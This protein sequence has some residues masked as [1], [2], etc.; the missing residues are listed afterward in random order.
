MYFSWLFRIQPKCQI[1]LNSSSI[2]CSGNVNLDGL[3]A[4]LLRRYF[5]F[6]TQLLRLARFHDLN[7][8]PFTQPILSFMEVWLTLN[9]NCTLVLWKLTQP[10]CLH[11]VMYLVI[12][13]CLS[14]RRTAE[15]RLVSMFT[16]NLQKSVSPLRHWSEDHFAKMP[17]EVFL[18][19]PVKKWCAIPAQGQTRFYLFS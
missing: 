6:A 1:F 11:G 3:L 5:L 15:I 9:L 2:H 13:V 16:D 4:C 18:S 10:I 17:H 8:K 14:H 19:V 7:R 12:P